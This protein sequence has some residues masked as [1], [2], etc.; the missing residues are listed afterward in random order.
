M[1]LI[2]HNIL[3]WI[4]SSKYVLLFIG[5]LFEGPVVMMASGFLYKLGQFNLL[6]MYI[7]LLVGD[8]VADIGWYCLGRYGTRKIILKYGHLIGIAPI[9]FEKAEKLFHKYHK[10]ILIM[11]KL[12]MG[13]GLS[14]VVLM[15]AGISKVPFKSYVILNLIGGLIWTAF[16]ITIGY[17][18]GNVYNVIP[19]SM[20]IIFVVSIFTMFILG[21]RYI[22]NYLKTKEI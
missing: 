9:A 8:F 20:K 4:D 16:L 10:K 19:R 2:F 5:T 12:T 11:S 17:F 21:I 7:A 1:D 22:N 14:T 6:P 15:V 13:F 3:I 18:L